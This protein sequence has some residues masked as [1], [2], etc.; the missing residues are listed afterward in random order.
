MP[1]DQLA[2]GL[3]QRGAIRM[4]KLLRGLARPGLKKVARRRSEVAG[5][6][7][8]LTRLPI[9]TG[10][11]R[12]DLAGLAR[13]QHGQAK[14][15]LAQRFQRAVNHLFNIEVQLPTRVF[16]RTYGLG[17]CHFRA[18]Q[19]RQCY[20]GG[21]TG[22]VEGVLPAQRV[23]HGIHRVGLSA[24]GATGALV[25]QPQVNFTNRMGHAVVV[26]AHRIK[27]RVVVQNLVDVKAISHQHAIGCAQDA[28]AMG[29][30]GCPNAGAFKVA[31]RLG[32]FQCD[33]PRLSGRF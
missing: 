8:R 11:A 1:F 30:N 3:S 29:A 2:K 4:P 5:V 26:A 20:A 9:P 7:R 31:L 16:Q 22:D 12:L 19:S 23:D 17:E 18:Y 21:A 10:T 33:F 25:V 24:V 28:R 6:Q 14:P 15:G 27:A 13:W 32:V